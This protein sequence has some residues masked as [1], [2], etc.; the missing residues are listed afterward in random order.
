MHLIKYGQ[1][2]VPVWIILDKAVTWKLY[3]FSGF[4]RHC[5]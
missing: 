3:E 4:N 2:V 1:N 5:I